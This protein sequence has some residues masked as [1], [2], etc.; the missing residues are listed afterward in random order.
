[1]KILIALLMLLLVS[2][3][4]PAETQTR[5]QQQPPQPELA[6]PSG[7][8]PTGTAT[9]QDGQTISYALYEAQPGSPAVILL[10]MLRRTRM[11]WDS[12][13]KWLQRSGFTVIVPDLRGHGQST[14]EL[15]VFKEEDYNKMIYDIGALKSILQNQGADTKRLAIVGASVG[16]NV[17]YNYALTDAD[18]KTVVLL[19]PGLDYKGITVQ[20][21]SF[22]KTFLVVASKDDNYSAAT[23][24][25]FQKNPKATIKMYEDAG[26]GTNMFAKND[27]AP[28]ILNWLKAN[29]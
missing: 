15:A 23:A 20:P 21:K 6:P 25:E 11:D 14:G 4:Q 16:A 13:A 5:P 24:Q 10:H 2:C 28:T 22:S 26:H 17:A 27:L 9:T 7:E 8:L 29:V 3:S 19:S 12:V 18:V 1:M